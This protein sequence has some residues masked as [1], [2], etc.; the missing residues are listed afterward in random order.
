MRSRSAA[1]VT[2]DRLR[3][4]KVLARSARF[5]KK[6][7]AESGGNMF[8][9][10]YQYKAPLLW[11]GPAI[12]FCLAAG[13]FMLSI[14]WGIGIRPDS[15]Y[16]LGLPNIVHT[17]APAYAWVLDIV[18]QIGTP[19]G[20]SKIDGAAILNFILMLCNVGLVWWII[21]R[22]TG[23]AS[24]AFL[25]GMLCLSAPMFLDLHVTILSEGL[26]VFC[27]LVSLITL[28]RHVETGTWYFVVIA[29]L[30]AG[31]ATLTRFN[32]APLIVLGPLAIAFL[33]LRPIRVRARDSLIFLVASVGML[34]VWLVFQQSSGTSGL[35]REMALNGG[36]TVGVLKQGVSSLLSVLMPLGFIPSTVR[37]LALGAL[38]IVSVV[39]VAIYF[40][41]WNARRHLK[42]G[43][44]PFESLPL[45]AAIFILGHLMFLVL[46]LFIEANLPLKP[47]YMLPVY[48]SGVV[49]G[50]LLVA[51]GAALKLGRPMQLSL[52]V[53][54][55]ALIAMNL[56]RSGILIHEFREDGIFY[57]SPGWRNSPTVEKVAA[58]SPD[59]EVYTNG[60]DVLSFLLPSRPVSWIPAKFNRRTGKDWPNDPFEGRLNALRKK[61][62]D[63]QAV[64]VILNKIEWRFYMPTEQTLV[65]A[66]N[67]VPL[68]R[69]ADGT[70]YGLKDAGT[71]GLNA[72]LPKQSKNA[73]GGQI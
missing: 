65:E 12:L 45:I 32:G 38:V 40:K 55:L 13:L 57:A 6:F 50:I 15:I 39:A 7:L 46:S 63:K 60:A 58:I 51:G 42:T 18:A 64:V 49:A 59:L 54:A 72:R 68:A 22:G 37:P 9:S 21:L 31:F 25:G 61:L 28:A 70:I 26:F 3:Y 36:V 17:N 41:H 62:G 33:S 29:G 44:K 71:P 8:S 30:A 10:A 5:T 2:K 1:A 69:Q 11:V 66:L 24:L 47:S 19:I 48:V 73:Q 67:L 16:Y 53:V 56:L 23:K 43:N 34:A 20:L 27:I 52:T 4:A 14:R 35:G